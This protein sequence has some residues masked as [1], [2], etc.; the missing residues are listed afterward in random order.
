MRITPLITVSVLLFLACKEAPVSDQANER[1]WLILFDGSSVDSL[2][3]YGIDYFPDGVWYVENQ[4]LLANPD[5]A[6]RDLV[7]KGRY[8]NFELTY[9]WAVDTAANSGVFFHV[10]E[11]LAM[12][13]GNGNSPNWLDNF[14]VQVLDDQYFPD[15]LSTRSAGSLYD[16]IKPKNK[17]LKPIGDFNEARLIHDDGHVEHWLN[18]SKVLEFTMGSPELKALL[19]N[20]KFRDNPGYHSDREGHIMFQH[21]GQRVYYKNIRLRKI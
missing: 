9:E 13:A 10:Q 12:E 15:T 7:T 6:N 8:E 20:S 21:H 11:E 14:E 1:P 2:R 17:K 16:L 18:G 3:G 4:A 19:A 5:T